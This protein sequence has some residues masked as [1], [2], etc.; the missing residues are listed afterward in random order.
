MY[1]QI[2]THNV[3]IS[4]IFLN[5]RTVG[6]LGEN[7][8]LP[9]WSWSWA[10]FRRGAHCQ[11]AVRSENDGY[12]TYPQRLTMNGWYALSKSGSLLNWVYYDIKPGI[13]WADTIWVTVKFLGWYG[14]LTFDIRMRIIPSPEHL[15]HYLSLLQ[16]SS[17]DRV[18]CSPSFPK[19]RM[20]QR[21]TTQPPTNQIQDRNWSCVGS[22]FNP[23]DGASKLLENPPHQISSATSPMK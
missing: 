7:F 2:Y 23:S 14:Y 11:A 1:T 12:L 6:H 13:F 18:S 9:L 15:T 3:H 17:R 4:F 10:G 22:S 21:G 20:N 5:F 8:G 16:R 19:W